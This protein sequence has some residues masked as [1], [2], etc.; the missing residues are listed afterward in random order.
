[1]VPS[2]PMTTS[3]IMYHFNFFI[4]KLHFFSLI[5]LLRIFHFKFP[6]KIFCEI[7]IIFTRFT[8]ELF[9]SIFMHI[10]KK[11]LPQELRQTNHTSGCRS[12]IWRELHTPQTCFYLSYGLR[13]AARPTVLKFVTIK[14]M[15]TLTWIISTVQLTQ[16]LQI[17]E[18]FPQL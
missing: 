11:S 12:R 10:K 6:T 15:C 8:I 2:G 18:E 14:K 1:M 9:T 16:N 3:N 7:Q 4:V 5:F 17:E 13:V